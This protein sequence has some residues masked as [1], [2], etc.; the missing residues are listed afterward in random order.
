[1]LIPHDRNLKQ[2]LIFSEIQLCFDTTKYIHS[3]CGFSFFG[4]KYTPRNNK[5][6]HEAGNVG[7]IHVYDISSVFINIILIK[8]EQKIK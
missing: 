7:G 3:S 1:M 6:Y 5:Y 4:K 8:S 2:N